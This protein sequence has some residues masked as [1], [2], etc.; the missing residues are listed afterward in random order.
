MCLDFLC[1]LETLTLSFSVY[2]Y[3]FLG[4]SMDSMDELKNFLLVFDDLF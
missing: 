1:G 3:V 4:D 2:E